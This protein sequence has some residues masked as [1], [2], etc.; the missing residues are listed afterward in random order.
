ASIALPKRL[1]DAKARRS[2]ESALAQTLRHVQAAVGDWRAMQAALDDDIAK[3]PEGEG[4]ALLQWFRMG[5]LTQLGHQIRHRDG[6][7][8]G[9]PGY[10]Q[11]NATAADP[12]LSDRHERCRDRMARKWRT[13]R[14]CC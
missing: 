14:R 5:N 8:A 12:L 2:L 3:L 10:S 4:A 11:P 1:K 13:T 9:W 7:G 6:S